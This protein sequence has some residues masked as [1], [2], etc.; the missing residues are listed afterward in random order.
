MTPAQKLI[1]LLISI[2]LFVGGALLI[3]DPRF[4]IG[5][6]LILWGN[7]IALAGDK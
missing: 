6:I 3:K 4:I 1:L 5:V 2:A 7:N